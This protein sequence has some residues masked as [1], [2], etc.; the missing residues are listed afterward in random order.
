MKTID[1]KFGLGDLKNTSKI[2]SISNTKEPD[3][4]ILNNDITNL[5]SN[6]QFANGLGSSLISGSEV[7]DSVNLK[8]NNQINNTNTPVGSENIMGKGI[9]NI[10]LFPSSYGYDILGGIK[11]L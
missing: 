1:S 2:E 5:G 4:G 11:M 6:T 10:N 8:D 3:G 9:N 7:K